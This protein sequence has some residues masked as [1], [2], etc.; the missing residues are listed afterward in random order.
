M[1]DKRRV[2]KTVEGGATRVEKQS[3]EVQ[4]GVCIV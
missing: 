3:R 1:Y 4:L 2:L